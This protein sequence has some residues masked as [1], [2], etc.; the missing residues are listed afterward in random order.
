MRSRG[1]KGAG[2]GVAG[3]ARAELRLS[4]VSG[5]LPALAILAG[6]LAIAGAMGAVQN[7]R[8]DY[9]LLQHTRAEYAHNGMD[10]EADLAKPANVSSSGDDEVVGNLARY[11]YDTL[12]ATIDA[13]RPASS[14]VEVAKFFG[15]VVFPV[16]FFLL[17]LWVSTVQ[18][19]FGLEKTALVRVGPLRL[20]AGR[21]VAVIAG[22]AALVAST[23]IVDLVTRAIAFGI[24]ASELPLEQFPPLAPVA[25]A[26]PTM[27]TA[28]VLLVACFFGGA[29]IAVGTAVGSF[30][31]PALLFLGWDLVLPIAAVG[32]PRNW[33]AVLGHA[34][35]RYSDAFQL[36][37]PIPLAEWIAAL[38]AVGATMVLFVIPHLAARVRNPLAG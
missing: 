36:T 24:L 33:F 31:V 18:R 16:L 6:L 10:F 22:A 25:A 9:A 15:F 34:V 27:Q 8:D 21:Q 11:D 35:F 29:G 23:L 38:L 1:P 20:V 12:S 37:R 17:G 2:G 13:S 28:V 5:L 19:R 14:P 3:V 26:N 30:A 32:D 7:V 4:V